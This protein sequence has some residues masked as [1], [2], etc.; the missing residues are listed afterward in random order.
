MRHVH[1]R[2]DRKYAQSTERTGDRGATYPTSI[3]IQDFAASVSQ[4]LCGKSHVLRN[5]QPLCLLFAL[6]SALPSFVFNSLQPLFAK[7]PGGGYPARFDLEKKT[8][9]H[10]G[11]CPPHNSGQLRVDY[12]PAPLEKLPTASASELYT[13][14]TVRSLVICRTSWNLLPR[15]Q[16]LRAAPCDLA[17]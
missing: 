7:H 13:S 8:R 16:S 4:C 5:L 1:P 2:D 17:L 12:A 3:L 15:W 9:G 6:F 14:K 10:A 11:A